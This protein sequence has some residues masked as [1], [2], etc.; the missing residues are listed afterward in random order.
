MVSRYTGAR[1]NT[2]SPTAADSALSTAQQPAP[3]GGSPMPRAPT[4]VSGSGSSTA[5]HSMRCG[6]SRIVGGRVWWNRSAHVG[7]GQI[8][9][10]VVLP[11]LDVD[12]DFGKPCHEGS[13]LAVVRVVVLR[14]A[15]QA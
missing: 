10:D 2:S 5:A 15:H 9:E 4:G 13:R 3:T 8:V 14:D 12:F 1:R 6:A 11:G 7:D